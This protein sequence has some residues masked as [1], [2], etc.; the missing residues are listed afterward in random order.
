[1]AAG[2]KQ[3]HMNATSPSISP[4]SLRAFL[5]AP[6]LALLLVLPSAAV[7][8]NGTPAAGGSNSGNPN[9]AGSA[10]VGMPTPLA[11]I[12]IQ[13][14]IGRIIQYL[15]GFSGVIALVMFIYGGLSWMTAQ[16]NQEKL[17]KARNTLVWSV[18]G[19]ILI[20]ASYALTKFV[21]DL[22]QPS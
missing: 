14:L 5:L 6:L 12:S 13:K 2:T 16:G 19:L 10:A 7:L 9:I 1:M 18:I 3:N 8:A 11:G 17:T 4:N 21:L 15:L 20:F 22:L